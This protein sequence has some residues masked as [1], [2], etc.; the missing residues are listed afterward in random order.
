MPRMEGG[1]SIIVEK[2]EAEGLET[3]LDLPE[4]LTAPVEAGQ[5]IGELTILNGEEVLLTVPLTAAESVEAKGVG[6][7]FL[8]FWNAVLAGG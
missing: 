8:S 3:R 6:D 2:T 1:G 4:K 7:L 5:Q